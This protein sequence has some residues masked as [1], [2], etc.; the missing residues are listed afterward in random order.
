M[1]RFFKGPSKNFVS[2]TLDGAINASVTTITLNS[3][4][5]LQAPGYIVVDRQDG[6]GND[7]ASAREVIYFTGISGSDLTGCSRGADN[8]TARSHN[9][10]ALVEANFTEGMWN[11]M[12]EVLYSDN[13]GWLDPDETWSYNS[14]T[15]ITVPS[16]AASKYEEGD[17]VRF[18]QGGDYKYF[19]IDSVA[20]TQLDLL[21]GEY[22]VANSTITNNYYSHTYTPVGFPTSIA[23]EYDMSRQAIIN[24]NFDIW[25]RST[26]TSG[27]SSSSFVADRWKVLYS[28]DGGTNP[29]LVHSKST[30]TPGSIDKSFYY[31]NV[32]SNGTGSGYGADAYY[33]VVQRIEYGTRYLCGNGRQVTISFWAKSDI[34]DKKI[35]VF[36]RQTYGSGGTPSSDENLTGDEFS[37]STSWTRYSVT[38]DCNTLSSKTFG[39][40]NNDFLEIVFQLAWG[41]NNASLGDSTGS[42]DFGGAGDIQIAQVQ[43]NTGSSALQFHSRFYGEEFRL[44]QR[45]YETGRV[46]CGFFNK[47]LA[48]LDTDDY[49]YYVAFTT[50][51]RTTP[52]DYHVYNGSTE[53]QSKLY[54]GSSGTGE[55]VDSYTDANLNG[56][57]VRH[58]TIPA[59]FQGVVADT[60][61]KA[62]AE[63]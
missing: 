52:S 34:T 38:V 14:S 19:T 53:D 51:K 22:T 50:P 28:L 5:N 30:L 32:N 26:S 55:D 4:T 13:D 11:E 8:S 42:E 37:L 46:K 9:D 35:I 40:S 58:T 31:Y 47:N 6:N 12:R 62:D 61:F 23:I 27:P 44:C 63:L 36:A 2:T 21:S 18:K 49:Y 7:T 56:F 20:D 3:T 60:T 1:S 29:T 57:T 16:G 10:G 45:Y 41:S 25:Q 39:T 43:V 24:G 48:Q 59:N 15:S 33:R 17:K 54:I